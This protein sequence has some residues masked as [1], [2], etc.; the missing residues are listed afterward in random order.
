MGTICCMQLV[1][2]KCIEI[3]ARSLKIRDHLGDISIDGNVLLKL[4]L[5]K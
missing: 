1:N 3:S 4:I 2:D 5:K